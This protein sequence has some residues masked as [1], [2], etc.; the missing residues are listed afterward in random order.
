MINTKNV[1]KKKLEY[2]LGELKKFKVQKILV[3]EY[4]KIDDH[5]FMHK[6]FHLN[7]KLVSNDSDI[8]KTFTLI[9]QS[10]MARIKKLLVK[11]GLLKRSLNVVLR[12][13][14]VII[15]GNNSIGK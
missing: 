5:K 7:A 8:D 12:F 13:L 2:L 3:S 14:S 15:D 9:H 6:I 11:I 4:K 10:V 1:I